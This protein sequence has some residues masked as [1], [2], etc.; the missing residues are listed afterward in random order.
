ME[1]NRSEERELFLKYL[2][3]FYQ[4]NPNYPI[5]SSPAIMSDDTELFSIYREISKFNYNDGKQESISN[6]SLVGVQVQLNNKFRNNKNVNVFSNGYFWVIENRDGKSDKEFYSEMDNSI[7]LYVS[8]DRKKIYNVAVSL[9]N[10]MIKENIV[11]QSKISKEMRNDALVCRIANK[12]DVIKIVD[13]LNGLNYHSSVSP[14]PFV[15]DNGKVSVA[16]DGQLSYNVTLSKLLKEYLSL[17]RI[18]N[19]LDKVSCDDFD[20][21]IKSQ[22][23]MLKGNQKSYFMHLYEIDTK[24]KCIDFIMICNLISKNINNELSLNEIFKY[25]EITDLEIEK[26]NKMYSK[27]DEDKILYV[28]NGL[29]NYYSVEDVHNIIMKF[30]DTGDYNY[31]TRKDNIRTIVSDNFSQDDVKNIVSNL[32]YKAFISAS[33]VT[34]DKY[35]YDWLYHAIDKYLKTGKISGFTREYN[36]RSIL[37][38]VIPPVLLKE[39]INNKL[40]ERGMELSTFGLTS[41]MIEEIEKEQPI[42]GNGRN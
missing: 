41:L 19:R 27:Y 20:K 14:N 9:F 42:K 40:G 26:Q 23:E 21:F 18:S 30:I 38:L 3:K 28:I 5:Y 13:F 6:H 32:G 16:R 1:K 7:K 22:I 12:D 24:E 11:T 36:V 37:G 8:V 25:S 10:F 15:F 34:Y 29:A 33:R 31:F 35:G 4:E 2:A 17:Q 39:I